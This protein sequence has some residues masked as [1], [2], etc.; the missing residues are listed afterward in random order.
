MPKA[1]ILDALR[2]AGAT[3]EG[4]ETENAEGGL[5]KSDLYELGLTG[6]GG[7]AERRSDL[8]KSL[9]LPERMSANALLDV[10]NALYTRQEAYQIIESA[11]IQPTSS[12]AQGSL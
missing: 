5:K 10:L 3:F 1:V 9:G 11:A 2:R 7:S 6:S 12:T 4:E 8:L